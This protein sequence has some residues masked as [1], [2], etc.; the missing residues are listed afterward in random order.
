MSTAM[1]PKSF[2][3]VVELC[4]A[5]LQQLTNCEKERLKISTDLG[6]IIA[7]LVADGHELD[8]V[9]RQLARDISLKRGLYT[10]VTILRR[11]Y[12]LHLFRKEQPESMSFAQITLDDYA[13]SM[14]TSRTTTNQDDFTTGRLLYQIV[15]KLEKIVQTIHDKAMSANEIQKVKEAIELIEDRLKALH[16]NVGEVALQENLPIGRAGELPDENSGATNN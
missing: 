1:I 13:Q 8:N 2:D 16:R 14:K 7:S 5:L 6:A 12:Q 9:L 3:D 4:V 11:S 10:D 15:R